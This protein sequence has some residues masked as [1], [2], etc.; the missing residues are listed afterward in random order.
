MLSKLFRKI[1][2]VEEFRQIV[3]C[4]LESH[5]NLMPSKTKLIGENIDGFLYS[6]VWENQEQKR[7]F[8]ILCKDIREYTFENQNIEFEEITGYLN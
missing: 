2:T 5:K 4:Y 8:E 7:I 1:P 6:Q 3:F